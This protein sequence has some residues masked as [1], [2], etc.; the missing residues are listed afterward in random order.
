MSYNRINYLKKVVEVQNYVLKIQEQ[1]N[2]K[3]EKDLMLK[4]I[5][6]DFIHPKYHICYKTF[7][8]YLGIN[9]KK[10]LKELTNLK[11]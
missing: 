6:W 1:E 2:D 4:E 7:H 3:R 10:Q 9:A 11:T 5:F 8:T